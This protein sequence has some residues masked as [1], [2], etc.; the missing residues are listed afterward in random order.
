MSKA[1][2]NVVIKRARA[3]RLIEYPIG[4]LPNFA[5]TVPIA[6]CDE[7]VNQAL[8]LFCFPSELYALFTHD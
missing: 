8:V 6:I 4:D 1:E 7:V 5:I 2:R 3:M